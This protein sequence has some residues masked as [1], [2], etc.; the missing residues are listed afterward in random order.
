MKITLLLLIVVANQITRLKAFPGGAP[1]S[2]CESMTP[3]H[4]ASP[5]SAQSPYELIV[6]PN[7]DIKSGSILRVT[8]KASND[9]PFKGFL[10]QARSNATIV[11]EF[12]NVADDTQ[13]FSFRNCSGPQ[14]TVT[15][16]NADLKQN[17][18]FSWVAPSDYAGDVYFM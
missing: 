8:I 2:A 17:I 12:D 15:H 6:T 10:L 7:E 16:A 14:S 1:V 11:G 18:S 3:S 5:Q 4:N 13:P 9:A